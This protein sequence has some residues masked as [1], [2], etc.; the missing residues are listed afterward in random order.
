MLLTLEYLDR[1]DEDTLVTE[2]TLGY[3]RKGGGT[4]TVSHNGS[5]TSSLLR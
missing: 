4:R 3:L 2:V 5:L 1:A